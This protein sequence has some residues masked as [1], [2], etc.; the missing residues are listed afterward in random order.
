[1]SS[2]PFIYYV[3][4]YLDPIGIPYYIGKGKNKRAYVDHGT[5]QP[6]DIS[7]IVFLE[8]NLSELGAFALERRYI[9][10]YGRKDIG[11]GILINKTDGG[12]G[13]SG[14]VIS[15]ESLKRMSDSISKKHKGRILSSDWK[16]KIS[17]SMIGK[18]DSEETRIKKSIA[19]KNMTDETRRKLSEAAK[20]R[21]A[22]AR[23]ARQQLSKNVDVISQFDNI[24]DNTQ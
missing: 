4:A 23:L 17:Q 5:H 13:F 20:R 19:T 6:P 16:I 15:E 24:L 3:Y 2:S 9:S 18:T 11:T 8:R 21:H 22:R 10:W 7:N 1:M 14:Y 12:E